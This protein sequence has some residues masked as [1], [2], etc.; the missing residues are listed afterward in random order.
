M[1]EERAI[2]MLRLSDLSCGQEGPEVT[3]QRGICGR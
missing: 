3:D 2:A 1:K